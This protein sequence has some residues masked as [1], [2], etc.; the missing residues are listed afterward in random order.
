MNYFVQL[1]AYKFDK[2]HEMHEYLQKHKLLRLTEEEV[3]YF[4]NPI[5]EKEVEQPIKEFPRKKSQGPHVFTSELYQTFKDQ[6][7]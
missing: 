2:L 5:S 1:Y 7:I 4:K 3:N 6:F